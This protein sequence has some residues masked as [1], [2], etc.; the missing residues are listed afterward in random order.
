M[1]IIF[2]DLTLLS[3]GA[4]RVISILANS[5]SNMGHDVEI[6]LYYDREIHYAIDSKVK[7]VVAEKELRSKNKIKHMIFRRRHI[8][9]LKPDVVISFL[10]PSRILKR[11]PIFNLPP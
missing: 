10:A 8:K 6:L 3:G 2:S 9:K 1:R 7:I 4:E 11:F 5:L